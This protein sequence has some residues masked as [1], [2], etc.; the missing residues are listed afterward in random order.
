MNADIQPRRVILVDDSENDN[1]FHDIA[2]RK[3]GFDGEIQVFEK[4][5]DAL[6]FLI[7]DQIEI[8]T[9]VL[10]DISMPGLCGFELVDELASSLQPKAPL[11]VFMLSASS[12]A[13]DRKRA[14]SRGLV[15]GL[16]SKPLTKESAQQL[17]GVTEHA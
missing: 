5:D 7:E 12:W 10:L 15:Q 11:S 16:L 6:Q 4:G 13:E 17:L 14:E 2:L 9:I 1:F 8:P 3:A